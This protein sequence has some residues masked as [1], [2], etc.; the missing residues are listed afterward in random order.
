ML[1]EIL[2]TRIMVKASMKKHKRDKVWPRKELDTVTSVLLLFVLHCYCCFLSVAAV[3][4]T[5]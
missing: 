5:P 3:A 1:E 4:A 2:S